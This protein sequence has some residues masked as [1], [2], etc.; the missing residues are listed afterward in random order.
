MVVIVWKLWVRILFLIFYML[1]FAHLQSFLC[2]L[3]IVCF[4]LLCMCRWEKK[5]LNSWFSNGI[6]LWC[7]KPLNNISVIWR[8]FAVLVDETGE[9]H[10]NTENSEDERNI[11]YK[12]CNACYTFCSALCSLD[13]WSK[14][15]FKCRKLPFVTG[16]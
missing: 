12:K 8:R 4:F 15:K 6:W 11:A 7:L 13:Y 10:R 5:Y 1:Y 14:V 2:F 3:I 16:R 9:N